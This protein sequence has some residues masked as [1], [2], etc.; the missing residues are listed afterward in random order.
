ME[1]IVENGEVTLSGTVMSKSLKRRAEDIADSVSAVS[2]VENRIRLSP[3]SKEGQKEDQHP[4]KSEQNERPKLSE[5]QKQ[6]Q[7]RG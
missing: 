5:T 1:V 3:F 4:G 2:N 7:K 6:I